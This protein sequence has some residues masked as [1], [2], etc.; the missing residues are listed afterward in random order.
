MSDTIPVYRGLARAFRLEDVDTIFVLTGDGNMHWEAA[1]SEDEE[2]KAF[3]VWHEHCTVATASAYAVASGKVGVA[4]V[5]CGPGVTQ[6]MTA[7]ATAA[8]SRIPLVVFAGESPINA[9]WY[10]QEIGQGPL[11]EATG[12]HY[13]AAH[14]LR[15]MFEYVSEAFY[16][17]KTERRPVV[18]GLPTDLQQVQV[19]TDIKYVPSANLIPDTGP[20][21]PHPIGR[22][23]ALRKRNASSLSRDAALSCPVPKRFANNWRKGAT[24]CWRRR[25][26]CVGFSRAIHVPSGSPEVFRILP[27]AKPL[28]SAIWL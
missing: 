20:V 16:I 4:S 26:R 10:N 8:N 11:V 25:S 2:V 5:T 28:Q 1:L 3:H 9:S 14:S 6:L 15:R 19:P 24:A 23:M 18:L 21:V 27:R 17:A 22:S 7:L 12:A 13:I